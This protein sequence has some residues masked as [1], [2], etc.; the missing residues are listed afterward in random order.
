V[1]RWSAASL[2]SQDIVGPELCHVLT[3]MVPI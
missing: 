1:V 3:A 2:A